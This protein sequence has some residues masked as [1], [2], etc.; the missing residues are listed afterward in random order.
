MLL[1]GINSAFLL[2]G[3]NFKKKRLI[4]A[5]LVL[6]LLI[7]IGS[8]GPFDLR[9][10]LRMN[11]TTDFGINGLFHLT[12]HRVVHFAGF[13]LLSVLL[14]VA[15]ENFPQRLRCLAAVAAFAILIEQAESVMSNNPFETWDVRDDVLAALVGLLT[16]EAALRSTKRRSEIPQPG[17]ETSKVACKQTLTKEIV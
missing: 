15:A 17:Q 5:A 3:S 13:G 7:A 10:L 8:V 12:L 16:V 9:S 2:L 6:A 14:Y 11:S 4:C 1:G